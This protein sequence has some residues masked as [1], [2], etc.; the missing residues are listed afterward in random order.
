MA[1]VVKQNFGIDRAKARFNARMDDGQSL[2]IGCRGMSARA[3]L[4]TN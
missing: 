4:A 2:T 3:A 1:E